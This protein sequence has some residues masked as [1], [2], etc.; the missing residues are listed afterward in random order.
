MNPVQKRQGVRDH[1][2]WRRRN[3]TLLDV[4]RWDPCFIE[5]L[6]EAVDYLLQMFVGPL[7]PTELD[8]VE[9]LRHSVQLGPTVGKEILL[10]EHD[11]VPLGVA[12]AQLLTVLLRSFTGR[13]LQPSD[14]TTIKE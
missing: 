1:L 9:L 6:A 10:A 7:Q 14:F 8:L 3:P 4:G 12:L 11:L 5:D 13:L 2:D